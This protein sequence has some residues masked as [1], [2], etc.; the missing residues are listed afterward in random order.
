MY[1][2]YFSVFVFKMSLVW[3]SL[4]DDFNRYN[5]S[6]N[7]FFFENTLSPGIFIH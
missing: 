4:Y 3:N 6:N 7:Y 5:I 2:Q 1:K